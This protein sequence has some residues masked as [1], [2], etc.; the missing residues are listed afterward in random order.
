MSLLSEALKP[1]PM[2]YS[3]GRYKSRERIASDAAAQGEEAARVK[4]A[5][6]DAAAAAAAEKAAAEGGISE[7]WSDLGKMK[8]PTVGEMPEAIS[9][10]AYETEKQGIM[11]RFSLLEAS[12]P[13]A[14]NKS[15]AQRG[16]LRSGTVSGLQGN[17][18][19]QLGIGKSEGISSLARE[20]RAAQY[21][22]AKTKFDQDMAVF[23]EIKDELWREYDALEGKRRFAIE[24]GNVEAAR[25]ISERMADIEQKKVEIMQGQA[26]YEQSWEG[27]FADIIGTVAG[28]GVAALV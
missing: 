25:K 14:V 22:W 8:P 26:E 24:Q 11:D 3:G 1:G 10:K 13:E 21:D 23:K 28:L 4:K 20:Q 2:V 19:M 17:Q 18:L 9:D 12:V 16:A 5:E 7:A 27:Q 15:A 6:E